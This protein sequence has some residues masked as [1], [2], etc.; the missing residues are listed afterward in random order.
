[1]KSSEHPAACENLPPALAHP[2]KIIAFDWDGT[3]VMSRR[4]DASNVHVLLERLLRFGIPIVVITGTSFPNIDRQLSAAI[5]GPHK[6]HL[7]ISTNRGS[8]VYGFAPIQLKESEDRDFHDQ[9]RPVLLWRRVATTRENQLLTEIA[10]AVRDALVSMTGLD[11][12]VIYNRLNRRKIDLIPL[13]EWRDPPKSAIDDLL[14]AVQGRLQSAGLTGGVREVIDLAQRIAREKGLSD[15]CPDTSR[16]VRI[17]ACPDTS[18]TVRIGAR[19]TSDVKHIEVG[20]TDKAEAVEW[21]VRELAYP[22]K[23]LPEDILIAGDEFGP[24]DGIEGSDYK[25]VVPG[26]RGSILVSVGREPNGVPPEV[27]HL[28]G[29]PVRF[30]QILACQVA[31]GEQRV[32]TQRNTAM[33]G[34]DLLDLPA[35]PTP[36]RSWLLVEEGFNLAR[37]HEIESLFTVSNGYVGTRGS[38]A[39]GSSLSSP[40]T[41]LAGIFDTNPLSDSSPELALAPDWTQLRVIVEGRELKL[42]EG[43]FLEHRRMLDLRQGMLWR[44]WRHRD[45]TGRVTRLSFLR[46]ASIADRHVLIQSVALT[47][48][49]YSGRVCLECQI[50]QPLRDEDRY[51]IAVPANIPPPPALVPT[52]GSSSPLSSVV[53][54]VRTIATGKTIAFAA[55][56]RLRAEK[57]EPIEGKIESGRSRLIE[58]WDWD[59]RIGETYRL[60]RL[61]CVYTSRDTERP[62]E[63][64]ASRLEKL[65]QDGVENDITAHSQVWEAYWRVAD[66][67]VQGD[68]EAQRALR[69]AIYHLIS[70]SNPEDE[71]ASI[72][73]RGFTGAV[74]KGH[75][76]WDTE[77]YMLP[78]YALTCPAAARALLTYRYHTLPAAR[79]KADSLGYRGALYPWESADTGEETTPRFVL[80]P[81]GEVIAVLSGEQEH[82]IS[83]DIAYAVWQ[84]WQPSGD[85]D[86]FVNAGAEIL[87]ETARFWA[88]RG[89]IEDDGRY[90]IR[91]VIGPDEYHEDVDDN[92]Y[93]NVMAQWNMERGAEVVRILEERWPERWR[94][95][96]QRLGITPEEPERWLRL[97]KAMYTG[98]DPETGL[99]EQFHGYFDLE[100]IDLT[101]YEGRTAPMDV[102]L[103]RERIR[104]SKVLKQPDVVMLIY[105]LWDRFSPTVRAANF[106]YYEPRA[107]HGSSLSPSIHA[108]VAARLGDLDLAE[109]YFK[110]SAEI[111]LA[112][113]MGNAAGGVHLAAQGG[114]WQATVFG[115]AGLLSRSNGLALDPNLPHRWRGL[116][117]PAQWRNRQLQVA[118]LSQP[119]AIEVQNE[120]EGTV[121]IALANCLQVM[122]G[123]GDRIVTRKT[124]AKWKPCHEAPAREQ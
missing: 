83:A 29:G 115:F 121:D 32:Q 95:L 99:F 123:P 91:H 19:I 113:N 111:D 24:I 116:R 114:L 50:A 108:L 27:I 9:S 101:A 30:Q 20:L 120:G 105:L 124:N 41:F 47:P 74:Y 60:D 80:A 63:M 10:D 78:F 52:D 117:F 64:A 98:F 93:T 37:E 6:R 7:Y 25:M 73:A 40:A 112:N 16:A 56:G 35:I 44:E 17:G 4:E 18:Q 84:Y 13:P 14:R 12:R 87:L 102:L 31:L 42:E 90:H 66:V 110:Q 39:E 26:V 97:A 46:L 11:I 51:T 34:L 109:R 94:D 23:V 82:H 106:R 3:A 69:F 107:G 77:I 96:A 118:V 22:M 100:E 65:L 103:G 79:T 59:V 86:F 75:V 53:L 2:F 21:L 67:Q 55:A 8:E 15:T 70:A 54:T 5:Q 61:A 1:M 81:D 36:N 72:G 68:D 33:G 58:R 104:R 85:D 38:L 89:Q 76:F 43:E 45:P 62:E 48:E 119:T 28:G 92:A 122:V 57:G 71:R 88:S 49:N